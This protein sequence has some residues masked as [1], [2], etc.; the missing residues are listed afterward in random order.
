V[1]LIPDRG[2]SGPLFGQLLRH[3][4]RREVAIFLRDGVL[5]V[6]DFIDGQG[7]LVEATIWFRFHCG[8]H[9]TR[10][11]R[12]RM[13]RESATPLSADLVQRIERLPRPRAIRK[14]R[15]HRLVDRLVAVIAK[16]GIRWRSV[17]VIGSIGKRGRS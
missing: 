10:Q 7:E 1:N 14:T 2:V 11:A 5:W 9:S 12:S 16:R 15:R 13:V 3:S 8:A 4:E 17:F 6:A